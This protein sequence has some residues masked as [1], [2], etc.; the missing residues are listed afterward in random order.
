MEDVSDSKYFTSINPSCCSCRD[1]EFR[2]MRQGGVC[3][4]V[5]RLQE[6]EALLSSNAAKWVEREATD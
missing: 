3:K 4:H 6:A 5:R 1:W 2:R